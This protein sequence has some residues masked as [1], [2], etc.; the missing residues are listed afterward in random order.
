MKKNIASVIQ[1][2]SSELKRRRW[3]KREVVVWVTGSTCDWNFKRR[4]CFGN[5]AWSRNVY[6][7]SRSV[8]VHFFKRTTVEYKER[9]W[10]KRTSV[11][12]KDSSVGTKNALK[13][14]RRC[15][16]Y[17]D[18]FIYF[19][20][21]LDMSKRKHA[22]ETKKVLRKDCKWCKDGAWFK[23]R[24]VMKRTVQWKRRTRSKWDVV[25]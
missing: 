3:S 8:K 11:T 24:D 10:F 13:K 6:C 17:L 22:F 1:K 20:Y 23:R 14:R 5:I 16:N 7:L 4:R 15:L 2:N 12:K 18:I 9:A 19:L 25:V 21:R